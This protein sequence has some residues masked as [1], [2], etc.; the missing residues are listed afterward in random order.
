M[1]IV[2]DSTALIGLAKIGNLE[3]F[4]KIFGEIFV[5]NA[6]FVEVVDRGKGRPGTKEVQ[7]ARWIR[8]RTVKDNRTVEMLVAEMGRG[9]AEVLVL[10]KELNADWLILDDERARNSAQSAEFHII[11]LGGILHLAKQ[12]GFIPAVKPLLDQLESKNFRLGIRVRKEILK[13]ANEK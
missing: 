12:L 8:K 10:G 4:E 1:K 9:E 5:P 13:K 6:V 11:G 7:D 3:L 2:C